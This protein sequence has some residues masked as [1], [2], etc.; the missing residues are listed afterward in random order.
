MEGG[1]DKRKVVA[2]RDSQRERAQVPQSA[3]ERGVRDERDPE[4]LLPNI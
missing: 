2:A 1:I 3:R 4:I